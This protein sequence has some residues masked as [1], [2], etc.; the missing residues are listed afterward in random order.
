MRW[1][2]LAEDENLLLPTTGKEAGTEATGAGA[3]LGRD[4]TS[5]LAITR[6][7]AALALRTWSLGEALGAVDLSACAAG[8]AS[9]ALGG[10]GGLEGGEPGPSTV[11]LASSDSEDSEAFLSNASCLLIGA[12]P[13]LFCCSPAASPAISATSPSRALL[14]LSEAGDDVE[15]DGSGKGSSGGFTPS[16][17]L[18]A[19]SSS[20]LDPTVFSGEFLTDFLP[21]PFL[22]GLFFLP[23]G[24]M[25]TSPRLHRS[26]TPGGPPAL[27][28]LPACCFLFLNRKVVQTIVS[29]SRK[30]S[31]TPEISLPIWSAI[32][33]SEGGVT[34]A[35]EREDETKGY[36]DGDGDGDPAAARERERA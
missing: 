27:T 1:P 18:F 35:G 32:G 10:D 31:P 15:P 11:L 33:A 14:S 16:G 3:V 34:V 30:N 22:N 8:A 26:R 36:K 29:P 23:R 4:P 2:P 19:A 25:V 13:P 17:A 5:L 7:A 9:E 28:P 24:G 6:L 12:L 20:A 21:L